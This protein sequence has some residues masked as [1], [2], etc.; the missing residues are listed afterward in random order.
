MNV[1]S[2]SK[3]VCSIGIVVSIGVAQAEIALDPQ[4]IVLEPFKLIPKVKAEYKQDSN[5][6]NSYEKKSSNVKVLQPQLELAAQDRNNQYKLMLDVKAGYYS[7]DV[8]DYVDHLVKASAHI[9][10]SA[11]ARHDFAASYGMQHDDLGTGA[12]EGQSSTEILNTYKETDNFNDALFKYGFEYGAKDAKGLFVF[13][14]SLNKKRYEQAVAV[15]SKNVDILNSSLGFR[16]QV[17]PKT[18]LLFDVEYAQGDYQNSNTA[19]VAS[20]KETNLFAGW[21]WKKTANTSGKVRIGHTQRDVQPDKRRQN[22]IW[23]IGG[24]W[25]PI[26]GAKLGFNTMQRFMDGSLPTTEI[27]SRTIMLNGRY[28]FNKQFQG[29]LSYTDT[30]DSHARVEGTVP[31]EDKT[32]ISSAEL[33]YQLRRWCIVTFAVS[34]RERHSTDSTFTYNKNTIAIGT[35]I[36]L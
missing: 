4:P 13:N 14:A 6:F 25:T 27:D 26:E 21:S 19:N 20:Y 10:P 2:Y 35:Q 8:N 11:R 32:R 31:R 5:V 9:E 23:D 3:I 29:I 36:S 7:V 1:L 15:S 30:N 22:V 18:K 16:Y 12:S 17:M 33:N 34:H 24:D 28:D